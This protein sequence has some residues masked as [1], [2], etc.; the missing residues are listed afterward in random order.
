MYLRGVSSKELLE[1]SRGWFKGG[2]DESIEDDDSDE[3][4]ALSGAIKSLL[5]LL[6]MLL[7]LHDEESSEAAEKSVDGEAPPL[8]VLATE[9]I[10]VVK[11]DGES[12]EV[13]KGGGGG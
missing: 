1:V 13:Q 6:L 8:G 4:K 12:R 11:L 2:S 5:L 9:L 3:D 10:G 7:L